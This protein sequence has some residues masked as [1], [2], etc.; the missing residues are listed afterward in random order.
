MNRLENM[1]E[2]DRRD[3]ARARVRELRETPVTFDGRAGIELER[4]GRA[5]KERADKE[6][7]ERGARLRGLTSIEDVL[8]VELREWA[9]IH[10]PAADVLLG[11]LRRTRSLQEQY[12]KEVAA[13][14]WTTPLSPGPADMIGSPVNWKWRRMGLFGD[15]RANFDMRP[16]IMQRPKSG[17]AKVAGKLLGSADWQLGEAKD[18]A[19]ALRDGWEII[20]ATP[21]FGHRDEVL[22]KLLEEC[23]RR[24]DVPEEIEALHSALLDAKVALSDEHSDSRDLFRRASIHPKRFEKHVAKA[25][26]KRKELEAEIARLSLELRTVGFSLAGY[27]GRAAI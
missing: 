27:H 19:T 13:E 2:Q 3:A 25:Q 26:A 11:E 1:I 8:S 9:R 5:A 16:P 6:E 18:A 4:Q 20:P 23:Y 14:G 17:I 7:V 21:A 22:V 10:S 15:P 12:E 24:G